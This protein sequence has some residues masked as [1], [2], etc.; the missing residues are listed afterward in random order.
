MK[1]STGDIEF[2]M[3]NQQHEKKFLYFGYRDWAFK[4]YDFLRKDFHID[5][6]SRKDYSGLDGYNAVL[7]YGWSWIVPNDIVENKTCV[8]L[9]SSPLP[10]YRGGS[11]LQNQ[12]ING[13]KIG[14][15]TLFQMDKGVD[16]GK[17]YYQKEISLE[18]NLSEIFERIICVGTDLS[19]RLLGDFE[20]NTVI[21]FEQ[22]ESEATTYKRRKPEQSELKPTD[23]ERMTAEQ[24][25][26]LVRALQDP[27]PNAFI[28]GADGKKVFITQ[29]KLED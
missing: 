2:D 21:Q 23:L 15:V 13:E 26:N 24:I 4:I 9:H 20:K 16:T 3:H 29:T 17:I 18:G 28:T 10:K 5:F 19:R 11:P 27:Y 6:R 25:H 12:I 8:C 7:F 1:K 14:A 22:D